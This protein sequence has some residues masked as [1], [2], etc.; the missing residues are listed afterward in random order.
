MR[1][2]ADFIC[3]LNNKIGQRLTAFKLGLMHYLECVSQ[4]QAHILLQ[5]QVVAMFVLEGDTTIIEPGIEMQLRRNELGHNEAESIL[6]FQGGRM[7]VAVPAHTVDPRDGL[8]DG[9]VGGNGDGR[10]KGG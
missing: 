7:E 3:I 1:Y 9:P 10:T 6:P 8:V 4:A 2:S 5:H